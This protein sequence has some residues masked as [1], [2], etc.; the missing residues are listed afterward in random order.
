MDPV[1]TGLRRHKPVAVERLGEFL[2]GLHHIRQLGVRFTD[3]FEKPTISLA[4]QRDE[5]ISN[6]IGQ[7]VELFD[8]IHKYLHKKRASASQD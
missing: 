2:A 7:P 8:S 1:M 5:L 6:M 3:P 4:M